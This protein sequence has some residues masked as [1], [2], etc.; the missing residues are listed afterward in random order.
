MT[1]W[2]IKNMIETRPTEAFNYIK[3]LEE[4]LG[5]RE[6]YKVD[7]DVAA[8]PTYIIPQIWED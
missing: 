5:M 8:K 2:E 3:E 6:V 7:V 4:K 1:D